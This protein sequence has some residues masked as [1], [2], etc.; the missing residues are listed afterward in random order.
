M[1]DL[2]KALNAE[3]RRLARREAKAMVAPL[4]KALSQLRRQVWRLNRDA[5]SLSRQLAE[6]STRPAALAEPAPEVAARGRISPRLVAKLR[7]RLGLSLGEFAVLLGVSSN[8]VFNWEH[9]K[10]RPNRALRARLIAARQLGRRDARRL[11][12]ASRKRTGK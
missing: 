7:A 1:P 11:V 9:G 2:A 12:A 6:K 8:S 10:S 5:R 4:H 3:I